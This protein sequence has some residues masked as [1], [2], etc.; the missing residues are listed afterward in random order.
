MEE[1]LRALLRAD[2][3]TVAAS[4]GRVNW[5]EHPQ[6]QPW[7]GLVLTVA[8]EAERTDYRGRG[9]LVQFRVQADAYAPSY[10]GA[11]ALAR[12]A[13]ACLAGHRAGR[14]RSVLLDVARDMGREG[15]A[16]E[17]GRPFRIA[18]EFLIQWRSGNA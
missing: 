6:G 14:F 17:A 10:A 16:V 4:G 11:K 7:P 2:P 1:E 3:A 15:D 13:R 18:L 9:G 12:A 8:S 5:I